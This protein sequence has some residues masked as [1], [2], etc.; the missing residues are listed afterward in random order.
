VDLDSFVAA[1]TP[2]WQRLDELAGRARLT[3]VEAD[4]LISLYQQAATH[5]SLI[6]SRSPDPVLVGRLSRLLA[7]GRAAAVGVPR[8]HGWAAF[9]RG[10]TVTFPVA[11]Y[12]AWRWWAATA[13]ASVVGSGA[14]MLYLKDHPDRINRVVSSAEIRQ[15]AD[16]DFSDYYSAH[17]AT[18][19]AA[20]VWT[21]NVLVAALT[22]ILGVTIVGTLYFLATNVI[23]IGVDGGV[24]LGAGKPGVFFGLILPHGLLELTAVFIAAGVGLR[25]GW[26]W[27]APGPLPRARSLAQAGRASIVVALGLIGVLFVSGVIE[28]FVTPSGLPTAIRIGIGIVVEVAFLTYLVVFG[29]AAVRAGETGDLPAW[30]RETVLPVA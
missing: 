9:T 25:T 23:N 29:R 11:V 3:G 18:S 10:V 27:I 19:F 7:R 2:Q 24:M 6:Q 21:N 22:L 26:A 17:P 1:H 15:L 8:G 13:L 28:A 4:E 12:S 5:L 30:E 16:H 20:Q 14:M